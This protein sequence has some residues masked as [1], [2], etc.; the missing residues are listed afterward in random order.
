MEAILAA[1]AELIYCNDAKH[2]QWNLSDFDSHSSTTR[3]DELETDLNSARF[4]SDLICWAF[5]FFSSFGKRQMLEKNSKFIFSKFQISF[6]R[7]P[8]NKFFFR[9]WSM[10]NSCETLKKCETDSNFRFCVIKVNLESVFLDQH[11]HDDAFMSV[12]LQSFVN[13]LRDLRI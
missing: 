3:D 7:S 8:K 4:L 11:W 12:I 10:P 2:A 9:R 6:R 1:N 13:N 5:S